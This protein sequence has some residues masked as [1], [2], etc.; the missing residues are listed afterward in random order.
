MWTQVTSSVNRHRRVPAC[1]CATVVWLVA[2]M[3]G[4]AQAQYSWNT[5]FNFWEIGA[6]WTPA[7]PPPP[8]ADVFIVDLPGV[9]NNT[10]FMSV[11]DHIAGLSITDGM[12]LQVDGGS[13]DVSVDTFISGSNT[14]GF[15]VF[16]SG[17]RVFDGP[18]PEFS[19][20]NLT[21]SDSGRV[22][23]FEDAVMHVEGVLY[24]N[25]DVGGTTIV[26]GDGT[27]ELQGPGGTT[28]INDGIIRPSVGGRLTLIQSGN[29]SYNL[30]GLSGD[31]QISTTIGIAT[32]V[33]DLEF[34]GVDLVDAF[35]GTIGLASDSYL[36]M[37]LSDGWAAD[38]DSVINVNGF[39]AGSP[40]RLRGTTLTFGGLLDVFGSPAQLDVEAPIVIQPSARIEIGPDDR[41]N[42]GAGPGA[43]TSVIDGGEFTLEQ[44]AFLDFEGPT[45]VHGGSFTTFSTS[46]GQ[47]AVSFKGPTEWAGTVQIDGVGRQTGEATV[48][49]ATTINADVFDMD[50]ATSHD[51]NIQASLTVN[52]GSVE[53]LGNSVEG[54]INITGG[55]GR[56]T[57]NLDGPG[58][59][60]TAL[61][62]IN[63]GPFPGF[64]HLPVTRI[65]GSPVAVLGNL[66]VDTGRAIVTA[67]ITLFDGAVAN[68]GAADAELRLTAE[69]IVESGVTFQG[70][71]MLVN[72]LA[73][74]MTLE[75]G[76]DTSTVEVVNDGIMEIGELAG[77]AAVD[78]FEN[79]TD[80][81]LRVGIGGLVAGDEHDQLVV[82]GLK[83]VLDGTL[84]VS[85]I[86]LG[87]G[88]FAPQPGDSFTILTAPT[89]TGTF[90]QVNFVNAPPGLGMAI[91]YGPSTVTV[92]VAAT[93]Q[94]IVDAN[95][96][97]DNPWVAG[98]QPFV[99]VLDTGAGAA[100]TAGIGGAGTSPQGPTAYSPISVTFDA[101]PSPAPALE[102]VTISCT[103]GA[104][105]TITGV[106]GSGA[107]PY[108]ITL[109]GPIPPLH[110]TTITFAGAPNA[111][112]RYQSQPGN[113]NMDA[114]TNTQDLLAL[115]QALNN[116]TANQPENI[117]RYNMNRSVNVNPVNTQD[118]LRLVQL[119][120]GTNTTQAFNGAGAA[121][122]P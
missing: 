64:P 83:A 12:R 75:D 122:C 49:A 68:I 82:S 107:G 70:A 51:W 119:L 80:G 56:L 4:P 47:G 60:W 58:E 59:T 16:T 13:L 86:D 19:T 111:A 65:A 84:E 113:A 90:A 29:G 93:A 73:G 34:H 87:G 27:I 108:S 61:D 88:L 1:F 106:A 117:A 18:L 35:S 55:S 33:G 69:S 10:V 26:T 44:G 62:E 103:G 30:D 41:V 17:L 118:L 6:N 48:S 100:L 63:L 39:G 77:S 2:A 42:F 92:V 101:P 15:D 95:P 23:L 32:S 72:G 91:E 66:N 67:P 45:E 121:A 112:L 21:L 98:T 8:N 28:L 114:A 89:V 71:G 85:L 5:G 38:A 3:A 53:V 57:I 104:C 24:L 120:N 96:P 46:F 97:V 37:E 50:G 74:A 22:D 102:N 11:T 20:N 99:D 25:D 14:V 115:V 110:C 79:R 54:T 7:G 31:G 76:V 116:G 43:P 78:G 81:T 109:S 9:E 36:L 52:A 40:A 94:S 105:P